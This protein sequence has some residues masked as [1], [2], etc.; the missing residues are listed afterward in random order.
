MKIERAYHT[1]L[2]MFG[3]MPLLNVL[4]LVLVFYT[5]GSKFTLS[6]GVQVTLPATSFALGSQPG[7]EIASLT[8]GSNPAIYYRD[9]EV[10]LDELRVLLSKNPSAEKWL[11]IKADTRTPAGTVA[12]LSD[13]ALRLGYSVIL[14]G[15]IPK[16]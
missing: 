5:L 9:R 10:T 4:L 12:A 6:P 8:G 16:K 2:A 3:I 15:S 1:H 11:V 7:A 13:E 14:A